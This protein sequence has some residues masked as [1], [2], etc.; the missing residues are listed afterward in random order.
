MKRL[1]LFRT[2]PPRQD[3]SPSQVTSPQFVRFSQQF[4]ASHLYTW[5]ERGT[6]RVECLAQEH[7]IMSPARARIRTARSGN[8]RTDHKGW[9]TRGE[10]V[11]ATSHEDKS[12]RVNQPLLPQNLSLCS[13][14]SRAKWTKFGPR[15]IQQVLEPQNIYPLTDGVFWENSNTCHPRQVW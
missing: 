9:L 8:E 4:A 6:V 7:N 1:G 5:V 14:R 2:T 11:P 15:W 12:H 3:A 13:K 10:L